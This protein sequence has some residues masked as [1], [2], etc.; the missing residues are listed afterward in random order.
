M[1]VASDGK[2][3]VCTNVDAISPYQESTMEAFIMHHSGRVICTASCLFDV[4]VILRGLCCELPLMEVQEC[5]FVDVGVC[6][7][8]FNIRPVDNCVCASCSSSPS[9]DGVSPSD[10]CD[11]DSPSGGTPNY[12]S[13]DPLPAPTEV[14]GDE[15]DGFAVFDRCW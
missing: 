7:G 13:D 8:C 12:S 6:A 5:T 3:I 1:P 10:D 4:S 15:P 11:P 14:D 2:I 9:L